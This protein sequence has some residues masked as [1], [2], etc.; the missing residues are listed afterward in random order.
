VGTGIEGVAYPVQH[1]ATVDLQTKRVLIGDG[2]AVVVDDGLDHR[3]AG[4]VGVV[5]GE[6]AGSGFTQ[7]QGDGSAAQSPPQV[8]AT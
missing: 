2:A 7:H 8:P 6:G 5:V 1:D 3:Q 4:G